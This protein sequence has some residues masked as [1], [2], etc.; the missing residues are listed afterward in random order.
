MLLYLSI[1]CNLYN[2]ISV[3]YLFH[4]FNSD[5]FTVFL[6]AFIHH[7]SCSPFTAAFVSCKQTKLS[8]FTYR[9]VFTFNASPP[10]KKCLHSEVVCCACISRTWKERKNVLQRLNYTAE[11]QSIIQQNCLWTRK[12][13]NQTSLKGNTWR[14]P[15]SPAARSSLLQRGLPAFFFKLR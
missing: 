9:Y 10:G 2:L 3:Y 4:N 14:N 12:L 6:T 7:T 11:R 13:V 15:P 1:F 5:T 8:R